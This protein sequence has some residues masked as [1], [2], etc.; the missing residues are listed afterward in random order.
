MHKSVQHMVLIGGSAGSVSVIMS[1]I[2]QLPPDFIHPIVIVLHRLKNV[3][4]ELDKILMGL[5]KHKRVREPEDK[6]II[7][8]KHIYL[9]P[10][11]YHLLIEPDKTFSLDYSEPVHFSRPSIDVTFE[12]AARVFGGNLTAILLSGANQDGAAGLQMIQQQGGQV[13]VQD[14]K[15][16]EYPTMPLAAIEII[17][18]VLILQPS[19]LPLFFEN[20]LRT[21]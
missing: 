17:P 5:H 14:P 9:A 13:V 16:A 1:L 4:S 18:E 10:Q 7:R 3:S 12:S 8:N 6:D 20:L 19:G 15:T 21:K 11:N 2:E